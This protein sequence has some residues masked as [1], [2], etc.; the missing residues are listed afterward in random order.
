[1][2]NFFQGLLN[3]VNAN[4]KQSSQYE[5]ELECER[6]RAEDLQAK[7]EALSIHIDLLKSRESEVSLV[8]VIPNSTI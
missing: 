6:R 1:M 8:F 5:N 7:L 3:S 4:I 2:I